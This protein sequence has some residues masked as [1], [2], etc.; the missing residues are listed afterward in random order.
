LIAIAFGCLEETD[1]VTLDQSVYETH[2]HP[3]VNLTPAVDK[4]LATTPRDGN[5]Q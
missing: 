4:S 1:S 5:Q 3:W 2:A